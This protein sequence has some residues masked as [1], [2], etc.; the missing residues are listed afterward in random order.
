MLNEINLRNLYLDQRLSSVQIARSLGCS[1]NKV[2]YWLKKYSIPKRAIGDAIY[3]KNHPNGDPFVIPVIDTLEKSYLYGIGIGLYWGE[4]TKAN[5][6]S[7]RLGNTDPELLK[8]FIRFL[9]DLYAV[10][11]SDIRFGLQIFTDIDPTEALGFWMKE[12]GVKENQFYKIHITKSGSIGT[13][14]NKSK[15]GVVTVYYHN[16]RL[17]D[18]LV[19]ALPR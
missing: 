18:I 4:G 12:F 17:R 3:N 15:Y 14:K 16:K 10:E 9:T 2:N 5:K 1:A 19:N 8:H 7:I 13:Y 6:Y 11:L